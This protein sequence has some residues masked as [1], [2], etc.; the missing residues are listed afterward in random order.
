MNCTSCGA[1]NGAADKFCHQ[2]GA[3]LAAIPTCRSC[4]SA[5]AAGSKFCTTC[6]TAASP[7]PEIPQGPG[8]VVDGEWHRAP[9]EFVRR[10]PGDALRSAFGATVGGVDWGA[11][12]RGTAA[13]KLIDALL[14]RS[15]RVPMGSVGVVT[16]DGK[17]V[18]VLPPGDQTTPG[19]LR[20]LV[21]ADL[22]TA[23]ASAIDKLL[24]AERF[25]LYLVDRRPIPLS[26]TADL[27]TATGTR[28]IQ[29]TTLVSVG[30]SPDA[31]GAFLG[32]VVA[33]RDTLSAEDV[34]LRFRSEIERAVTDALRARPGSSGG[35]DLAAAEK[36]ARDALRARFAAR[37]GLGFDLVLAPRHTVHRMDLVLGGGEATVAACPSCKAP[38]GAGQKFCTR[39]GATQP[40]SAV[41]DGLYTSDGASIE[42]DLA[43]SV[44]GEASPKPP[45]GVLRSAAARH[46]RERPW[47][48]VNTPDGQ[49][50]LEQAL[51]DAGGDALAALGFRL[52]ALE[53]VDV[54]AAGDQ[55][56]LG[57]RAAIEQA[58]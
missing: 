32:D 38:I 48:A 40:A 34:Y 12:L 27:P 58:K 51:A 36:T 7:A 53:L 28:T 22:K 33:D 37:T 23:A 8:Y 6:G 55:W 24:G 41:P 26:F 50:A 9:G 14:S 2:C 31:L 46:L 17:V 18:K 30:A 39:C 45:A 42:L 57:A 21:D 15:I 20:D 47:T 5:L 16:R 25:A 19:L 4:G 43:L 3:R 56:S 35:G 1:A 54:R 13:G 29:A 44:Q 49:R 10:V 11:F 52:L